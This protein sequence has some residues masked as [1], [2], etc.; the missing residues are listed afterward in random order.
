VTLLGLLKA[1]AFG[2]QQHSIEE[3]AMAIANA[4]RELYDRLAIFIDHIR[5]TGKDLDAAVKS[6]NNSI[7][8]LEGRLIPSIRKLQEFGASTK[9][10]TTAGYIDT[11]IRL[12]DNTEKK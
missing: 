7:A 3:N 12:P 9:E 5:K 1:V 8:S 10:I 2:W 6:Y 4:S 11:S